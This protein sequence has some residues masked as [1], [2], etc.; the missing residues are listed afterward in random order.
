LD[1][2]AVYAQRLLEGNPYNFVAIDTLSRIC[3][4]DGNYELAAILKSRSLDINRMFSDDYLEFLDICAKG[5]ESELARGNE[6]AAE[7]YRQKITAIPDRIKTVENTLNA[8]AY[9]L[10]HTPELEIPETAINYIQSLQ[11]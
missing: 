1:S 8:D 11:S 6:K 3:Y 4:R 5:Y 9:R 10:K 7:F 2:A